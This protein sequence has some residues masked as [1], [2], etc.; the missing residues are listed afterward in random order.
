MRPNNNGR[1]INPYAPP[2]RPVHHQHMM[3]FMYNPYHG[4]DVPLE[5]YLQRPVAVKRDY[6]QVDKAKFKP[7][8]N[9][10]QFKDLP[11]RYPRHMILP[12]FEKD[13][14]DEELPPFEEEQDDIEREEEYINLLQYIFDHQNKIKKFQTFMNKFD[15]DAKNSY[16]YLALDEESLLDFKIR[17]AQERAN[18]I[19]ESRYVD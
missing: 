12:Q 18:Q 9:D 4:I 5:Y 15:K 11:E 14:P 10:V 6:F 2:N 16:Y 7:R 8:T 13:L 17:R 1:P 3:D 19:R